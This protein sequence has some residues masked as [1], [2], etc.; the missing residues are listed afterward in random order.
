[1]A[2]YFS[3]FFLF[4]CLAS[5]YGEV[6]LNGLFADNMVLQRSQEVLV[7]GT[8]NESKVTVEFNGQKVSAKV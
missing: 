5:S 8:S 1:M 4:F 6:K 3:Y 2:R 7:Y